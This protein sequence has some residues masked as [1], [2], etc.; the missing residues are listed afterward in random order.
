MSKSNEKRNSKIFK[1]LKIE[2]KSNGILK[3]CSLINDEEI[4]II[5]KEIN[6]FYNSV[7][8]F[9]NYSDRIL[10]KT[11]SVFEVTDLCAVSESVAR[12]ILKDEILDI[13]KDYFGEDIRMGQFRFI[14]QIKP[15]KEE[16]LTHCDGA[17]AVLLMLSLCGQNISNGPTFFF[18]KSHK[19]KKEIKKLFIGENQYNKNK[20]NINLYVAS[21]LMAGDYVLFDVRTWHGRI[22]PKEPGREVIWLS[23]YPV[24]NEENTFDSLFKQSSLSGLSDNQMEFLGITNK[25]LNKQR[26][27]ENQYL[28]CRKSPS[29]YGK[30]GSILDYSFLIIS[31]SY[32]YIINIFSNFKSNFYFSRN[33]KFK[34]VNSL[35][36]K[37]PLGKD[38]DPNQM[39]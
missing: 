39:T 20:S 15:S 14:K 33:K 8:K 19:L 34:R 5:R 6:P 24:S 35:F 10:R 28:D 29:N 38:I 9:A 23:F 31:N 2:L 4:N 11:T 30:I 12:I 25:L 1:K 36:N 21:D 7:K 27:L 18:K 16:L 22:P 26:N 3:G 37:K 32:S 17:K 13:V